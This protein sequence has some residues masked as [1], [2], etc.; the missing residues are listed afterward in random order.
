MKQKLRE[1][2]SLYCEIIK[3]LSKIGSAVVEKIL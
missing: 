2:L 3:N 1:L